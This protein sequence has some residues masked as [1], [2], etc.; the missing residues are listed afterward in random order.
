MSESAPDP[1]TVHFGRD[2]MR[3]F[4]LLGAE[5]SELTQE[6]A[7]QL[8][9]TGVPLQVAFYFTAAGMTD[10]HTL[11]LFAGHQQIPVPH[12]DAGDWLR[13]GSDGPV[14]LCLR[15]DGAV[16]GVFL[17]IE[18]PDMFV[19]S[20]VSTFN[21]SLAVLDRGLAEVAAATDVPSAFSAFRELNAELRQIDPAAFAG[22]ENWWPR[23]LDD[24]RHTLN[25]PFASTFEYQDDT[26][27]S[28]L[29]TEATGPGL[30]HP[31]E[32]VWQKLSAA[33]VQPEQVQ[34]VYCELQPCMMPGHYCAAW[35]RATFPHAEFTHSFDYG[36]D[37]ESR[38]QGMKELITYT[39]QR[40]GRG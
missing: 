21:R 14:Q 33:G 16:Q 27:T 6:T 24:V 10:G 32:L 29:V 30:A 1:S 28:Q 23:V 25:F 15:P 9:Q 39:A 20:N 40:A 18:Q 12:D 11:A 5:R 4:S 8:E 13:L 7:G 36:D 31:E 2:G 37:A 22:R 17:G 26:G 34:R 35:M 38:E 19:S 3:R